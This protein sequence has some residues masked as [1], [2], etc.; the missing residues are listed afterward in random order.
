MFLPIA[1]TSVDAKIVFVRPHRPYLP[2]G[3]MAGS[4][5][6]I[7]NAPIVALAALCVRLATGNPRGPYS[8]VRRAPN[9]GVPRRLARTG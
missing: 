8:P 6:N 7:I 9:N 5:G 2:H 1:V 3:R 4:D